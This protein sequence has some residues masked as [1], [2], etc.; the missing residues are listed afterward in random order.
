MKF[1]EQWL[2][3]WVNPDVSTA[4]LCEQF[5]M[6]GL[7]VDSVEPAA[8]EFDGIVVGHVLKVQPHPDADKLRV[9]EVSTGEGTPLQ[10]VCGA[11]NVKE[12]MRVPLARIGAHLPGD[13]KIKRSKLRGIES[14]GMLCSAK[15]L[16]LASDASGLMEFP[17]NAPAGE[18]VRTFLNLNDQLIEID[19]TPN[20]GDCLGLIGIAR[21]CGVLNRCDVTAPEIK[22][23]KPVTD[24]RFD[25]EVKVTTDCPR[26]VG[27]II[28]G[29]DNSK[30]TPDW[31]QE[32]LRRSGLN[33]ISPVVDITNYVLLELGQPM[34]AFDLDK[35]NGGIRVRHATKGEKL[36][37]LD[38]KEVTLEAGTLVIADHKSPLAIAGVMGGAASG[39]TE[40]T[41]KILLESA[42]FSQ[43]AIAG[44]ARSYGLH[45]DSSYRFERGVDPEM[46]KRAIERATALL[47]EIVGGKAGPVMEVVSDKDLPKRNIIKLRRARI[48]KILGIELADKDVKEILQRLGMKV[49]DANEGWEVIAPGYRFDITIEVDLIE[50]LGRIYGYS[51]I[52]SR[53][54]EMPLRMLPVPESRIETQRLRSILIDRGYEEAITYSFVEPKLQTLLLPETKGVELANPISADMSV[55]RTSLW[56]G[57][58]NAFLHNQNRQQTRIRLFETGLVFNQVNNNIKQERRIA[59]IAVGSVLPEQWGESGRGTDFYDVKADVEALLGLGRKADIRFEADSCTCLHPGQSARIYIEGKPAGWVGLLHPSVTQALDVTGNP[60]IFEL[61]LEDILQANVAKFSEISR[62]PSIRRDLAIIIDEKIT[63]NKVQECVKNSAG[64]LLQNVVL[65]DMYQGK[66]IDSGRKSIALGLTLGHSSRTLMEEDVEAVLGSVVSALNN[67]LGAVLRD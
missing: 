34:H 14:E 60:V 24:D 43:D 11:S 49:S 65:F 1:S 48:K 22:D 25:I 42:F 64:D 29:I 32:K 40:N 46:Q 20:R 66:G 8:P 38:G 3:E 67:K 7:E 53:R 39:V 17:D 4:E 63:A 15:E 57:L 23:I 5:T 26:Y 55:M 21:E 35:L 6:A 33:S 56:P 41:N 12:N 36:V 59:G 18:D 2:R 54:P 27:R 28:T 16:G 9:C 19:L 62:F 44:K 51:K 52:K 58:I 31:M 13:I 10:I 30:S 37:L 61:L 45:T 50:E 47:I